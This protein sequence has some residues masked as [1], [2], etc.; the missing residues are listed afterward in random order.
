MVTRQ[1]RSRG[2]EGSGILKCEWLNCASAL[3]LVPS[4]RWTVM[5]SFDGFQSLLGTEKSGATISPSLSI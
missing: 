2:T 3:I 5:F 1:R 4:G